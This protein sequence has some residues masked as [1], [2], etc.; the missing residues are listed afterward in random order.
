MLPHACSLESQIL[1]DSPHALQSPTE[2]HACVPEHLWCVS[3]ANH[4]PLQ[5]RIDM[6]ALEVGKFAGRRMY[7][8]RPI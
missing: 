1:W 5:D 8:S 4:E 2:T 7:Q 6:L 3:V